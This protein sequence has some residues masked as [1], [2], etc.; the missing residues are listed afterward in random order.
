[1]I[2]ESRELLGSEIR[3]IVVD[4]DA[5]SAVNEAFC[6]CSRIEKTYSRFRDESELS[7][8]NRSAG[9][10][11]TVSEEFFEL[12][13]FGEQMRE[14]TD[15]AFDLTVKKILESWGYDKN[16]SFE[17]SRKAELGRVEMGEDFQVRVFGEIDLGGIG[18]GFA[19]DK[20]KSCLNEFKNFCINAGGDI[21]ARGRD[22]E[23][24]KWKIFFEHP[25]NLDEVIGFAEIDDFFAA[26]SS[27]SKRKWRDKHHLVDTRSGAPA[28][29][30]LAVYVQSDSGISADAYATAL[31]VS[32]YEKAQQIA[33]EN[34]IA[35]MLISPAGEIFR[36]ENFKGE[37][38]T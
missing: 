17:E 13:K 19:L 3:I 22:P 37:L 34:R 30:M 24:E 21:F 6:E 8:L 27:G 33:V 11:V 10:W 38:F 16:Y 35:V 4:D 2:N 26:A 28:R 14:K 15:G 36:T 23:G 7:K 5:G 18:K 25:M 31:F 12:I 29:E 1:M 9:E 32:G 20:M